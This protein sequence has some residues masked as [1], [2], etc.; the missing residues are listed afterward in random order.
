MSIFGPGFRYP[1]PFI[2]SGSGKRREPACA[3]DCPKF[4]GR[5]KLVGVVQRAEMD[6]DLVRRAGKDGRSAMRA[7]VAALIA[8]GFSGDDNSV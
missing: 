6:L 8:A 5:A 2:K 1:V 7:E 3:A 4:I